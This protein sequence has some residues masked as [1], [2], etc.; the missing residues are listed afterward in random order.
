MR[1]DGKEHKG[2]WMLALGTWGTASSGGD[3]GRNYYYDGDDRG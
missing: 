2:K 3:H 1:R